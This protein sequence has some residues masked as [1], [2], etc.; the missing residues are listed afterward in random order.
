MKAKF[1]ITIMGNMA[2]EVIM[3]TDH[4]IMGLPASTLHKITLVS[5][6]IVYINDFGMKK[7]WVEK[8]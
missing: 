4:E 3:A 8:V 2:E 7:V 1:K 6:T 5:G